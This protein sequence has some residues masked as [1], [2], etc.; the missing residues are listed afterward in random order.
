MGWICT[1]AGTVNN[2]AWVAST[3]Y[4]VGQQVNT[5]GKVYQCTTAGT[6][7]SS[8]PTGTGTGIADG[9]V[10]WDYVNTLAV[11]KGYGLIQA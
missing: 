9:T 5:G 10:T 7:G 3:A 2:I 6:S 11:F 4:T 8:A 1:T